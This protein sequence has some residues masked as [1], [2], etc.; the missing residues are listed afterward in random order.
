MVKVKFICRE[1]KPWH[2]GQNSNLF[3][4]F[5]LFLPHFLSKILIFLVF[6]LLLTYFFHLAIC[7]NIS[8]LAFYLTEKFERWFARYDIAVSC[9]AL[10]NSHTDTLTVIF[11]LWN[12]IQWRSLWHLLR[13]KVYI[14][15]RICICIFRSVLKCWW[16]W[17]RSGKYP[18]PS[19]FIHDAVFRENFFW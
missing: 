5:S 19:T 9:I 6:G 8:T 15:Q 17:W 4:T 16:R 1:K 2:F 12:R 14:L 18:L 10:C 3:P 11:H 13:G 7:Q